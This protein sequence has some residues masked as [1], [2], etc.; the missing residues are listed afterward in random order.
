QSVTHRKISARNLLRKLAMLNNKKMMM[1]IWLLSYCFFYFSLLQAFAQTE[2]WSI[3]E[4]INAPKLKRSEIITSLKG[5]FSDNQ[6]SITK[7]DVQNGILD[8][9]G[10]LPVK[11]AGMSGNIKFQVNVRAGAEKYAVSCHNFVFHSDKTPNIGES[12]DEKTPI[13]CPQPMWDDYHRQTEKS[14]KAIFK[15]MYSHTNQVAKQKQG[16]TSK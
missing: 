14:I 9:Y 13:C 6:F 7:E 15:G 16:T 2:K 10:Q 1:R 12:L 5:Y 8:G 11:H 3:N 4:T